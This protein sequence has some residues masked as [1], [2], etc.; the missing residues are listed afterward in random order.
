MRFSEDFI[1]SLY[2]AQNKRFEANWQ[3]AAAGKDQPISV[4]P[5]GPD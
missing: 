2:T 5:Q 4:L 3:T 1:A